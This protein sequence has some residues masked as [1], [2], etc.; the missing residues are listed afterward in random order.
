MLSFFTTQHGFKRLPGK[1]TPCHT[2]YTIVAVAFR[3]LLLASLLAAL[4]SDQLRAEPRPIRIG[5]TVS[6]SGK[7]TEPS[8][9]VQAG[10]RLW[11]RQVNDRGGVLGRP[12]ELVLRDDQSRED[13]ARR[14][15]K[16]LTEVDPVDLILS[17]YGSPLTLVASE[18]SE[19]NGYAML[20][21]AA[22]ADILFDR[23]YR[24]LFGVYA[25]ARRYFIGLLDLIARHGLQTVAVLHEDSPFHRDVA[26]GAAFWAR[27]F[28]LQLTL[29][30]VITDAPSDLTVTVEELQKRFPA[31]DVLI[32]SAYPPNCY[33]LMKMLPAQGWRP[34]VIA[35]TIAPVHPEFYEKAG[36]AAEGVFGP[37]QWEPDERIPFPGTQQFIRDFK[38]DTGLMPSYHAAAAYAACQIMERAVT[39]SGSLDQESIR[40]FIASMDSV[41]VIGRFKVDHTGMQI[42]HNPLLIQWQEGKKEIVYPRKLQTAVPRY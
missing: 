34:A 22:S 35:Q 29:Q 3:C 25:P 15:Y 42:G 37:S 36:P 21:A 31:T 14:H 10:Y 17:P 32:F 23:G 4:A 12:V 2:A 27:Q 26:E 16:H 20:A 11:A 28:R 30:R 13:T 1:Q 24:R 41:T 7:Y 33:R 8:L 19:R 6:L 5:A 18:I 38:A 40:S 9:M 39:A